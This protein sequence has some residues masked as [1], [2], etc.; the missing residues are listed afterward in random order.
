MA[1]PIVDN[2]PN[3][4]KGPDYKAKLDEAASRVKS[5]PQED[6]SSGIIDKGASSL[7]E[8]GRSCCLLLTAWIRSVA[9]R[10]GRGEDAWE[11]GKRTGGRA[12]AGREEHSRTSRASQ[13]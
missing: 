11:P 10:P 8:P 12:V 2:N 3:P 7:V 4:S 5:P 13:T 6:Q 9:I 1:E